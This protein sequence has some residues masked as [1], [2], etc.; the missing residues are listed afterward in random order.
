MYSK[1]KRLKVFHNSIE[2]N[3]KCFTSDN[4]L[5]EW[6]GSTLKSQSQDK[7]LEMNNNVNIRFIA[8]EKCI[9]IFDEKTLWSIKFFAPREFR[10]TIY[11]D[12]HNMMPGS[13]FDL[14]YRKHLRLK[15]DK[16]QCDSFFMN[17][18]VEVCF[19]TVNHFIEKVYKEAKNYSE[20]DIDR[21]LIVFCCDYFFNDEC[22]FKVIAVI[23]KKGKP[24]KTFNETYGG[25]I[26]GENE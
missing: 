12:L 5:G 6:F 15:Y 23:F 16:R 14:N 17:F 25:N 4:D 21:P 8:E 26:F 19:P 11:K 3:D 20:G 1:I 22:D 2:V 24:V 13:C 18:D 9:S 7:L 10:Y